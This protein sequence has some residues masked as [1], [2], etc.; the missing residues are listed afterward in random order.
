MFVPTEYFTVTLKYQHNL[1]QAS[2][3]QQLLSHYQTLLFQIFITNSV[4]LPCKETNIPDNDNH[5]SL[6]LSAPVL[7][8]SND[9]ANNWFITTVSFKISE[10]K[11]LMF[12]KKNLGMDCL[13]NIGQ[14]LMLSLFQ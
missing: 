8:S 5:S 11:L 10:E 2:Q 14:Y 3:I 6:S 7:P 13:Y 1:V 4:L 12:F 9:G